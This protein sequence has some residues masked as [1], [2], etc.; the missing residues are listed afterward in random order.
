MD[1]VT[2][3]LAQI[4]LFGAEELPILADPSIK[5][6]PVLPPKGPRAPRVAKPKPTPQEIAEREARE[7]HAAVRRKKHLAQK[8]WAAR[9]PV[10]GRIRHKWEDAYD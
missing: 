10:K 9:A 8:A 7:R 4:S 6:V 2:P 3:N 1:T 5:D